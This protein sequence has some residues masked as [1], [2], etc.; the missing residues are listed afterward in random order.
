METLHTSHFKQIT[1]NKVRCT[2][3]SDI[4]ESK[5]RHDYASCS[6]GSCSVDGG[7]TYVRVLAKDF[8]MVE[9]MTEYREPTYDE[10]NQQIEFFRGIVEECPTEFYS[11]LILSAKQYRKNLYGE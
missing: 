1:R 5:H 8:S 7:L 2:G 10:I 6:C 9:Y 3:C 11:N 4:I